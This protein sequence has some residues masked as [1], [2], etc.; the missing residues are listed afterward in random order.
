MQG[1]AI[2][3]VVPQQAWVAADTV[4]SAHMVFQV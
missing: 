2:K 1:L 3:D 4:I